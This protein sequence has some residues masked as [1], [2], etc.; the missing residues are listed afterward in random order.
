[1]GTLNNKV[2][3]LIG[4][5]GTKRGYVNGCINIETITK[6]LPECP[7]KILTGVWK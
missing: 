4:I 6:R 5:V 3:D 7:D 2:L 1:L